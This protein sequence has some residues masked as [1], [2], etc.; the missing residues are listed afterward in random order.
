MAGKVSKNTVKGQ[1]YDIFTLKHQK[2]GRNTIKRRIEK[3][4]NLEG[5]WRSRESKK[6]TKPEWHKN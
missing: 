4:D 5:D 3:I 6:G 2:K 1:L